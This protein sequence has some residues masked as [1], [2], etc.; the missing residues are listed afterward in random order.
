MIGLLRGRW[1]NGVVDVGGVGYV[2]ASPEAFTDGQNVE[3]V[4]HTVWRDTGPSLYGFTT[5]EACEVFEALCRVNRIGPAAA[6]SVL[7]TLGTAAAVQAIRSGNAAAIAASPG[8]GKKSAELICTLA[9]I[10]DHIQGDAPDDDIGDVIAALEALGYDTR[11][12][13]E[14]VQTAGADGERDESELLRRALELLGA[15]R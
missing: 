14:A 7:R 12:A 8:V 15:G 11:S 5:N 3:L 1:R 2:V 4:I 9:N 6:L 13:R 10:P